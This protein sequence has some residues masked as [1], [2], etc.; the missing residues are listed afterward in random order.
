MK[1][2][3]VLAGVGTEDIAAACKVSRVTVR[4]WLRMKDGGRVKGLHLYLLA[5]TLKV[6]GQW[7]L[8]GTGPR[9]R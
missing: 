9:K 7:L 8:T 4:S 2:A 6:R 1:A 3:M 5:V